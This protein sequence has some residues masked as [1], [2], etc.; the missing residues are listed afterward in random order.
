MGFVFHRLRGAAVG[1]ISKEIIFFIVTPYTIWPIIPPGKE[2]VI[3]VVSRYNRARIIGGT[4]C[5][6]ILYI[7]GRGIDTIDCAE[8]VTLFRKI[9]LLSIGRPREIGDPVAESPLS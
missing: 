2:Y 8:V 9:D 7:P 3:G 1:V 4:E 5:E 6:L